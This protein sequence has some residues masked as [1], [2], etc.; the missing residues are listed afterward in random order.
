MWDRPAGLL[1]S[2]P[3]DRLWAVDHTEHECRRADHG[4]LSNR[5]YLVLRVGLDCVRVDG[6][7]GRTDRGL[8]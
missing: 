2:Y 3:L 7:E 1:G 5:L 6:D 8:V 4:S